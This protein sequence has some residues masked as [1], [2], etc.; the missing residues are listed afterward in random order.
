MA[1]RGTFAVGLQTGF[2]AG[3]FLMSANLQFTFGEFVGKKLFACQCRKFPHADRD[4]KHE[5]R[6]YSRQLGKAETARQ[7][8]AAGQ[9]APIKV[10]PLRLDPTDQVE[11]DARQIFT[12][13]GTT[14]PRK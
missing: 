12:S 6:I 5:I 9:L 2:I 13:R 8:I 11:A 10:A 4:M 14:L 3:I 1:S 7:L